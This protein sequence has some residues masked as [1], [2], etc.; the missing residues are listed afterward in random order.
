MRNINKLKDL[1]ASLELIVVQK[2]PLIE[3]VLSLE[4]EVGF[5]VESSMCIIQKKKKKKIIYLKID[6]NVPT[7]VPFEFNVFFLNFKKLDST[8]FRFS[9]CRNSFQSLKNFLFYKSPL[10]MDLIWHV[11]DKI[12]TSSDSVARF[13]KRARD[14][15]VVVHKQQNVLGLWIMNPYCLYYIL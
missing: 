10:I 7:Y 14:W 5:I 11:Y 4:V 6:Q 9:H 1:S 12:Y 8:F 13:V 3:N 15:L 2:L